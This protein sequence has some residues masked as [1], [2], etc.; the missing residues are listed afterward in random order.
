MEHQ[1]VE[2]GVK[3]KFVSYAVP[4]VL[5]M[6][7]LVA[8]S[9]VVLILYPAVGGF[10][11][12]LAIIACILVYR[13]LKVDYEY[14][15]VTDEIRFDRIYSGS[16]RKQGMTLQVKEI[17]SLEKIDLKTWK[18]PGGI[19]VKD[20]SSGDKTHEVYA[21]M[22]SGKDGREIVLFEPNEKMLLLMKKISP[23]LFM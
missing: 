12:A 19:K 16:I 1:Y 15:F 22:H 6:T 13:F 11:F 5:G 20:F 3:R 23:K 2:W 21:A 18:K 14:V 7:I 8:A 9:F 17:Q 10:L 4:T